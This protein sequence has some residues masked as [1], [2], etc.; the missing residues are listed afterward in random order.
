MKLQPLGRWVWAKPEEK[1]KVTEAGIIIPDS[2]L[3][4]QKAT[5]SKVLAIG[6]DVRE[7]NQGDEV[8]HSPSAGVT[9]SFKD[10]KFFFLRDHD[11]M[12]KIINE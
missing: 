5:S 10:E 9:I 6:A 8:I 4:K 1:E 3:D 7:I 11:P 2:V 12:A